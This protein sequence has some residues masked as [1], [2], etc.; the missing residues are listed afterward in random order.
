L[1]QRSIVLSFVFLC[2][3][4]NSALQAEW[5]QTEGGGSFKNLLY[6]NGVL[7]SGNAATIQRSTDFGASWEEYNTELPEDGHIRDYFVT[8][9]TYLFNMFYGFT[10]DVLYRSD[11]LGRTWKQILRKPKET[12]GRVHGLNGMVVILDENGAG[13]HVSTDGGST[14]T[15]QKGIVVDGKTVKTNL[16]YIVQ[17]QN[18]FYAA[19]KR[20]GPILVSTDGLKTFKSLS[21]PKDKEMSLF[22]AGPFLVVGE[23]YFDGSANRFRI[24]TSEN[25]GKSWVTGSVS[26]TPEINFLE[27]VVEHKGTLYCTVKGKVCRSRDKGKTWEDISENLK[28]HMIEMGCRLAL[29]GQEL[30][31]QA[32]IHFYTRMA[33]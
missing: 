20:E 6:V 21:G 27:S 22:Q 10:Y 19:Q 3:F 31:L 32:C 30:G 4:L 23:G 29:R 16:S 13:L 8:D 9:G 25:G 26:P 7:L 5:K 18:A 15:F 14:W 11:D 2:L 1:K 12:L 24:H 33:D 28:P 17:L